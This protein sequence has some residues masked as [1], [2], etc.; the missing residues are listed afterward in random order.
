MI[1]DEDT[2]VTDATPAADEE[3]DP[4]TGSAGETTI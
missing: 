3:D 2:A 1:D 4:V